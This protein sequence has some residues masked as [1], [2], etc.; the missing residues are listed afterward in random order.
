MRVTQISKL[1]IFFLESKQIREAG[2]PWFRFNDLHN[3]TITY[4]FTGAATSQKPPW[5]MSLSTIAIMNPPSKAKYFIHSY[6]IHEKLMIVSL[7]PFQMGAIHSPKSSWSW[8]DPKVGAEE[9]RAG[10]ASLTH[11]GAH[12]EQHRQPEQLQRP[13]RNLA[14][15]GRRTRAQWRRLRWV[16]VLKYHQN[17][18]IATYIKP[19][20]N[21][22]LLL[23]VICQTCRPAIWSLRKRLFNENWI[24]LWW[25]P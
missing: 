4:P 3:I 7:L 1:V 23:V 25:M 24:A 22:L 8:A 17:K 12:E 10:G 2:E 21:D 14:G 16:V 18:I 11:D 9:Q 20:G 13:G 6:Q 5:W 15:S 19:E